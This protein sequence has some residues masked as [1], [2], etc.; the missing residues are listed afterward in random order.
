MDARLLWE[1]AIMVL[2]WNLDMLAH[3]TFA[4]FDRSFESWARRQNWRPA[5][6]NLR[7][8]G[9]VTPAPDRTRKAVRP[10]LT[11]EGRR[12]SAGG[13]DPEEAWGRPWDGQWR[14]YVFDLPAER[15]SLRKR[16]VRRLRQRRYGFL[17]NS[18]WIRPDPFDPADLHGLQLGPFASKVMPF[19]SRGAGWL[20]DKHIVATAWDFQEIND[21]YR[22]HLE[23][24]KATEPLL[25]GFSVEPEGVLEWSRAERQRWMAAAALDPFLP[26]QLL[27]A[28]YLGR[29]AWTGRCQAYRC[30]A[31][32]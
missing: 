5:L 16:L 17:Q 6:R 28:S 10:E 11:P 7:R 30:L 31:Q 27:P 26:S 32:G 22:A 19:E 1:D 9:Y 29:E 24:L 15:N 8:R 12:F 23:F 20:S 2:F 21:A 13:V 14:A 4:N 18:V 25:R 3:P